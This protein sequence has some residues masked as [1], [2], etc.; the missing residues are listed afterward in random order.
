[1]DT[2]AKGFEVDYAKAA[3][4]FAAYR[5]PGSEFL[6]AARVERRD[7][8][9]LDGLFGAAIIFANALL[10]KTLGDAAYAP[11]AA[12]TVFG[13]AALRAQTNAIRQR[14]LRF[15]VRHMLDQ[16]HNGD[17]E[18]RAA[19]YN[20]LGD[21]SEKPFRYTIVPPSRILALSLPRA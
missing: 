17:A 13:V 12:L 6:K 18:Q 1:M 9:L 14:A 11:C 10:V 16:Y 3:P 19:A 20:T 5:G 8:R 7:A 4:I 21:M 15:F 2:A